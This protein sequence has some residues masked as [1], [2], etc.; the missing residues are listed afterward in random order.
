MKNFVTLL[1]LAFLASCSNQETV[2]TGEEILLEIPEDENA[3]AVLMVNLIDAPADY[4]KVLVDI[5]DVQVNVS[6]EEE[7]DS[8]GGWQ[9]LENFDPG[10]ID[11]LKLT[12][13]NSEFLGS[14]QLP[15]GR[16]NQIRLVLGEN[17][18]LHIGE[19]VFPLDTPSSMQSGLKVLVHQDIV[20]GVVYDLTID[21]DA[22]KSIVQAGNSGQYNLKPVLR[23]S[24][25]AGEVI[26]RG[27]ITPDNTKTV[28]YAVSENM[29]TLSTFA[30][31]GEYYFNLEQTGTYSIIAVPAG[32]TGFEQVTLDQI[33]IVNGQNTATTINF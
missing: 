29:D 20:Q 8:V 10:L 24:M 22:A 9:S 25:N 12:G 7:E 17:N 14:M 18:S 30:N 16:I 2:V 3:P 6:T 32:D 1:L 23:T 13:G 15:T 33:S 31:N 27:Q 26:L 11:L 19:E 28:V 5:I 21:F 4:D